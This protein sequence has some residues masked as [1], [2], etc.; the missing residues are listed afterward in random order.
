MTQRFGLIRAAALVA[1]LFTVGAATAQNGLDKRIQVTP[2]FSYTLADNDRLTDDGIGLNVS[3]GRKFTDALMLEL[4]GY[5]NEFDANDGSSTLEFKGAGLAALM[6]PFSEWEDLYVVV[7]LHEGSTTGAPGARTNYRSTVFDTG[8]GYYFDLGDML[9]GA[10]LRAEARYRMD[11]HESRNVGGSGDTEH[12][13]GVFQ[14][15]LQI[16][17]GGY[18]SDEDEED[19]DGGDVSVV[20][21]GGDS[22]NDGVADDRDACPGTP[23]GAIVDS[24]GCETDKDGDGVSDR[25]DQ[26]P[27]TEPGTQVDS[28]G[29]PAVPEGCRPPFPGEEIDEFGCASGDTVVLRGVTFEFDK[30]RLTA[31]AKV[32]LDG[33][34]DTLLSASDLNVEVGGHTDSF[35]SEAYN[36]SLSERRAQSVVKYIEGR[37]VSSDRLSAKGYGESN[38]I[39]SNETTDGRELNR[40]VELKILD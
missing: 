32:I 1:G 8:L 18:G 31:N 15:G 34:A 24:R 40:R 25:L 2:A 6:S 37:G 26:C 28:V 7:A 11:S 23:A 33:V 4:T 29:C 12:Y 17:I 30:A 22:D 36:Q 13:D 35:G 21:A 16:P 19:S 27:G 5:F 3:V 14:L 10:K 38:P 9:F 39:A 20:A